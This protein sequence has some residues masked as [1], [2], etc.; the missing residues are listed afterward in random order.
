[1]AAPTLRLGGLPPVQVSGG[2]LITVALLAALVYP[3][4]VGRGYATASGAVLLAVVIGVTVIVSVLLHEVAH[5][6][7]ARAAG[8]HVE[9]IS[10][11]LWGGHT[12][13][14]A[15]RIGPWASIL[16]S[17]GGPAMNA[18]IA[19]VMYVLVPQVSSSP[20]LLGL[21]VH[22]MALNAGL[23]VFNLL[24]GLP[25]DGGRA[26]E[27]LLG[28]V[29]GRR[30]LGTVVTAWIG[31]A[32]AVVVVAIPLW[33]ILRGTDPLSL[34]LLIWALVIAGTLWQGASHALRGARTQS[35]VDALRP[36][37]LARPVVVLP[38]D[39]PADRLDPRTDPRTVLLVDEDGPAGTTGHVLDPAALASVPLA[40]RASTPLSAVSR[41][42]GAVASV[43]AGATG[44]ELVEA[45]IDR[46]AAVVLLR[47][48]M[49]VP[50]GAVWARD[51][52]D[53]L[54]DA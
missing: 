43:P 52:S 21:V 27:S 32:I 22:T 30:I 3:N 45:L 8:G 51:V 39:H 10:L 35:H 17:L 19:A 26:V 9:Q 29:T 18:L 7:L 46:R 24:P 15:G 20:A 25:M 48:P 23:A 1:M 40:V 12:R 38:M 42:L 37:E 2:T 49:G 5:A 50:T 14:R 33:R 31:R 44:A 53:R 6:V 34:M 36:L 11:T 54:P 28:A 47:D 16:I 41:P 4:L 13:Y